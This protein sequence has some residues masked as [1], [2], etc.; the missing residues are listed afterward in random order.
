MTSIET[1]LVLQTGYTQN[2]LILR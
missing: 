1:S 2:Y